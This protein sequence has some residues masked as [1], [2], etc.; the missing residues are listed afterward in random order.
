MNQSPK[1]FRLLA[2]IAA[3]LA[4]SA[5]AQPQPKPV[6]QWT[7]LNRLESG[8]EIQVVVAGRKTATGFLQSVGPDSLSINAATSQEAIPRQDVQLVRIKRTAHRGRN[9]LIGLLA[10][11]AGGLAAG[12]AIDHNSHGWFPNLG[13]DVFTPV[14]AIVGTVVGVA[15]PTGGWRTVYR[16]P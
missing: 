3:S 5:A 7:N 4:L 10:G 16:A 13:K 6:A 1:P 11:T 15:F 9:T 8:A 12:A 14:G 2:A